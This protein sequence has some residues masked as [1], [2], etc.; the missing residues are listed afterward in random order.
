MQVK[1]TLRLILHSFYVILLT[2]QLTN[3]QLFGFFC[4]FTLVK[5]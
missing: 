3:K 5:T 4:F 1:Q 2:N